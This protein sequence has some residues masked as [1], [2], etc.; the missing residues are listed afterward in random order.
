V[1]VYAQIVAGVVALF[2]VIGN[3]LKTRQDHKA[4]KALA[5][6]EAMKKKEERDKRAREI[7]DN[8]NNRDDDFIL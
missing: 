5:N 1:K 4:G 7:R 3:Y 8:S 2:N 6:Q